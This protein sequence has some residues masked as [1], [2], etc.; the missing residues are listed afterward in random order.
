MNE[1]LEKMLAERFG[2]KI[3]SY[4][5]ESAVGVHDEREMMDEEMIC[6]D[7][8]MMV[9]DGHCGCESWCDS[10]NM[11]AGHCSC[12]D[13]DDKVM[14]AS[15]CPNCGMMQPAVDETVTCECGMDEGKKLQEVTP[16]GYEKIV[17]GLKKNPDVDNPWAVAWSM[18][19]KGIKP[20][21][22]LKKTSKK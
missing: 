5:G 1:K 20:K 9:V 22:K 2:E 12:D 13:V 3:G 19:N 11:P 8:G 15:V 7:C 18:K 10:C 17:K 21:K 14:D 4:A 16:K 6:P